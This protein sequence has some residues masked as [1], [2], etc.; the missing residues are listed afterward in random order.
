MLLKYCIISFVL[1]KGTYESV[2]AKIETEKYEDIVIFSIC[3]SSWCGPCFVWT[4]AKSF[5]TCFFGW[6]CSL[7]WSSWKICYSKSNKTNLD[8]PVGPVIGRGS[9]RSSFIT[10]TFLDSQNGIH[11]QLTYHDIIV[12]CFC[13]CA[14]KFSFF[15]FSTRRRPLFSSSL[16]RTLFLWGILESNLFQVLSRIWFSIYFMF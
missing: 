2:L 3:K 11:F 13:L 1:F 14:S 6:A 10:F 12:V 9:F 5:M 16:L 7:D 4:A 8:S 15:L